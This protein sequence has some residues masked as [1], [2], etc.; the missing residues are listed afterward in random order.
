MPDVDDKTQVDLSSR[1]DDNPPED[2]GNKD[3]PPS[4]DKETPPA[5][6][7]IN[8]DSILDEYGLES[9][10]ELKEWLANH[11]ELKGRIGDHDFDEI[12]EGYETLQKYQRDWAKQEYD[13]LKE[14][15]TPEETIA[16][17]EKEKADLE[18]TRKAE[19]DRI[20]NA[21]SAKMAI[22][23]F[24]KTV[25]SVIEASK[26]VPKEWRPF[27]AEFMGVDNPI[28]EV[29]IED[30]AAVRKAAKSGVDKMVRFAR[31]IIDGYAKGK[32][33]IP[34]VTETETPATPTAKPKQAK[35]LNEARK[36]LHES[37]AGILGKS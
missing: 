8:V 15:E 13:K 16:R 30:R 3:T 14:N 17:L 11:R 12:V 25:N 21:E 6:G 33:D 4:G 32:H 26:D 28:N 10:E 7:K 22:D 27:V 36:I 23:S 20:K 29:D 9:P 24:N 1:T 37:L 35:N 31:L 2:D 19:R 34:R 18:K 5:D